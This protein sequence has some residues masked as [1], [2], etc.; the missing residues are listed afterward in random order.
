M[1]LAHRRQELDQLQRWRKRL[2]ASVPES[3]DSVSFDSLG[4]RLSKLYGAPQPGASAKS[5]G[6]PV[7][8][9][10]AAPR[11]DASGAG[12]ASSS[13]DVRHYAIAGMIESDMMADVLQLVSSNRMTGVFTVLA[14]DGIIELFCEEGS[15][16][17]AVGQGLLAEAAFFAAFAAESG[18]Y[19]FLET[20]DLPSDRT[21]KGTT[22]FLI[23]EALRQIDEARGG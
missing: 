4:K 5:V 1:R 20:E 13:T 21:I 23:L 11:P 15:F 3:I 18:R 12:D 2:E 9:A 10:P 7:P 22:Q 14:T 8:G 17:H 19:H 16:V 6:S